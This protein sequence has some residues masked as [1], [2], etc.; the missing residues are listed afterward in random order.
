MKTEEKKTDFLGQKGATD[1]TK[2][3]GKRQ[4]LE[5]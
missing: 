1:N 3:D 2:V 4:M 5:R